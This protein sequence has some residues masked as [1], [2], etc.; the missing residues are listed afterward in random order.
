MKP[1]LGH[2]DADRRQLADLLA[3]GLAGRHTLLAVEHVPAAAPPGPMLHDLIDALKGLEPTAVTGMT[4]LASRRAPR[5]RPL[6]PRHARR[7]LTRR[8]RRVP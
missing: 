1:M 2:H 5:R 3:R 8:Q 4:L 7:V 6:P